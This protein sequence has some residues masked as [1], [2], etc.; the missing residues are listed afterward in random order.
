MLNIKDYE[1]KI[2]E[3]KKEIYSIRPFNKYTL[4]SLK[5]W[6]N[7]AFSYASNSIEW[8]TFTQDEVRLLIEDGLTVWWKTLKELKEIEN[9]AKIVDKV[10]DFVNKDFKLTEDFIKQLHYDLFKWIIEE[11]NLWKY[12][13]M[14]VFISGDEMDALA[15]FKDIP[16]LMKEYIKMANEDEE[17]KLKHIAKIHYDFVKI[18]PFVD[19]N[20]RIA[21]LLMNI[22]LI[23]EAFL[24]IVFPPI[25]RNDYISSLKSTK[26]FDDFYKF[27]LWQMYENMKDYK[28]FFD[29]I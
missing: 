7:V 22:Y 3:I 23:K 21:R 26:T 28:R 8:N 6:F 24:P 14:Q 20:G 19:G 29:K 25:V 17:N 12:R 13:Q 4:E 11:E 1:S 5:K 2:Y 27:F 16:R 9:H 15:S 10:W 18:H